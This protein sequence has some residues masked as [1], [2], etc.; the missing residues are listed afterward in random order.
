MDR[1]MPSIEELQRRLDENV[2]RNDD[3][4]VETIFN[5]Y[6]LHAQAMLIIALELEQL[7][8]NLE[9]LRGNSQG[10]PDYAS[11]DNAMSILYDIVEKQEKMANAGH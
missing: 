2:L 11:L 10:V 6:R 8:N 3:P 4:D 9:A 1:V 5:F 7:N